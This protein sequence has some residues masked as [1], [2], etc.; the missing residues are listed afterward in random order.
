[1]DHAGNGHVD[2]VGC[3][4]VGLKRHVQTRDVPAKKPPV[5]VGLDCR[6]FIERYGCG[7]GREFAIGALNRALLLVLGR[8]PA[9]LRG[10]LVHRHLPAV[11]RGHPETF[12][13]RGTGL[14]HV[15]VTA[16]NCCGPASGRRRVEIVIV[17][18]AV[19][20]CIDMPDVFPRYVKF[21]CHHHGNRREGTLAHFSL[22]RHDADD[23]VGVDG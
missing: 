6:L 20:T 18:M 5:A 2:W 23:V 8:E 21:L 7:F 17:H 14:H 15:R 16:R 19:G 4:S 12:A 22:G 13:G 1:M 3:G 11:R 10:H 9:L